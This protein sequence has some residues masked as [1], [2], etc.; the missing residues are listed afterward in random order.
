MKTKLLFL[1]C[2]LL[3]SSCGLNMA[4]GSGTVTTTTRDVGA[5]RK[6]AISDGITARAVT[7]SRSVTIRTDDNLQPLIETVV[8]GDT[9]RVRVAG[10]TNVGSRAALEA[11]IS[12]DVFEGVSA[13]GASN[14]K[15]P[16]TSAT[17]FPISASGASVI[18]VSGLSA[19]T[20]NVDASGASQI[21]VTGSATDAT[22]SAAGGSN[23]NLTGLPL[24]ALRL[25][26]SGASTVTARVSGSVSGGVSGASTV[27]ITGSPS[28][29]VDTSGGS[30]ITLNN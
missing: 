5:F 12:N 18:D 20:V 14:V 19:T 23:L 28:N 29:G 27:V 24:T 1:L 2:G 17:V 25:D 21:T 22:A 26:V 30:T 10:I 15:V 3:S 6:I 4:F 7:G 9:L 8:E 16:A 11:D 13:S